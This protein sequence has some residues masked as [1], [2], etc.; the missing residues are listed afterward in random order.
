M[1][2]LPN[3]NSLTQGFQNICQKNM[4]CN[5]YFSSLKEKLIPPIDLELNLPFTE[6]FKDI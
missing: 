5:D 2:P 3:K 4:S 6:A 1:S